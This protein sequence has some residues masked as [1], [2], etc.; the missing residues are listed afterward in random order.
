MRLSEVDPLLASTTVLNNLDNQIKNITSDLINF[1]SNK[2]NAHLTNANNLVDNLL[3]QLASLLTIPSSDGSKSLTEVVSNFRDTGERIIDS[4]VEKVSAQETRLVSLSSQS[5]E[6]QKVSQELRNQIETQKGRLDLAIAEFQKQF[7][8]TER[9]RRID[10]DTQS[11]QQFR[12]LQI[13]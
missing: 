10:F 8:E 1:L 11:K 9:N 4:L 2:N 12:R 3:I 6:T 7:S 13:F 5:A